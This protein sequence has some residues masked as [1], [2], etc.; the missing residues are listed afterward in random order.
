MKTIFYIGHSRN[1][2]ILQITET[3]KDMGNKVFTFY[4]DDYLS[5]CPYW[6]KKLYKIGLRR[7]FRTYMQYW[8]KNLYQQLNRAHPDMV[9]FVDF[10]IAFFSIDEIERISSNYRTVLWMVDSVRRFPGMASYYP[11]F[12]SIYLFEEDDVR[13]MTRLYGIHTQYLP[14]GYCP[15]YQNSNYPNK[16]L[17][18]IYD[19]C[20]VGAPYRNRL[21]TLEYI[22][23][24][25]NIRAKICG[26]FYPEKYF[27]K[28]WIFKKKYPNIYRCLD[29]R[30]LPPRN[31]SLLY[32]QSKI[33]LN[34]NLSEH[35]GI[36]PRTYEIMATGSF[37]LMD[38]RKEYG[39]VLIP[40]ENIVTF[41]NDEDCLKK[42]EFYLL[43][44]VEREGIAKKGWRTVNNRLNITKTLNKIL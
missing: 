14:I 15:A 5:I 19:I 32:Q 44:D 6:K 24:H 17:V 26:P 34:I 20:F 21:E 16:K 7:D 8:K 39:P 27:W 25:S 18:K 36:S 13:V 4:T 37:E 2:K 30:F 38:E 11:L 22:L 40:G 1:D 9:L 28:K 23:S 29:N 3:L 41:Y 31:V 10:N 42:I 35:K 33:C 43:H 12:S